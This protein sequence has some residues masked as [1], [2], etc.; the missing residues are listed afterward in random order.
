MHDGIYR[1]VVENAAIDGTAARLTQASSETRLSEYWRREVGGIQDSC[2]SLGISEFVP[3]T[4][5]TAI[6]ARNR[7]FRR[8]RQSRRLEAA[9]GP[10][11]L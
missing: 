2:E 1:Q 9:H 8:S 11:W 6:P 5:L 7:Q 10:A 4:R 3:M